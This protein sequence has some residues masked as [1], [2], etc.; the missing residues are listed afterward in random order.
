MVPSS[1]E[2]PLSSPKKITSTM[3]LETILKIQINWIH[4]SEISWNIP[5]YK[6]F[7]PHGKNQNDIMTL[8]MKS[9]RRWWTNTEVDPAITKELW[10]IKERI[11]T[12]GVKLQNEQLSAVG[13]W[14]RIW[15]LNTKYITRCRPRELVIVLRDENAHTSVVKMGE[16]PKN[17]ML[18]QLRDELEATT[19]HRR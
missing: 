1:M 14:P 16:F 11:N 13:T 7:F 9:S 18:M 17:S 8:Q 10:N 6:S 4:W 15:S 3:E 5:K 2:K 19:V 12:N